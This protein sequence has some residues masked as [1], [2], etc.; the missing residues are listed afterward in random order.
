MR[1]T[2]TLCPVCG[3]QVRILMLGAPGMLDVCRKC[4]KE[5]MYDISYAVHKK[6]T[7]WPSD[8]TMVIDVKKAL[9]LFKEWHFDSDAHPEDPHGAARNYARRLLTRLKSE[10]RAK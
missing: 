5:G 9:K 4:D 10:A 1:T 3:K 2:R 7:P 6:I 8:Q